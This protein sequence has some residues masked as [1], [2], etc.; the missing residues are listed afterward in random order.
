MSSRGHSGQN[1]LLEPADVEEAGVLVG[2]GAEVAPFEGV[3]NRD[4]RIG[5]PTIGTKAERILNF[6][7]FYKVG[8]RTG[9]S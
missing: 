5:Y 8:A 9:V 1:R 7:A 2:F 6:V 4:N 3:P